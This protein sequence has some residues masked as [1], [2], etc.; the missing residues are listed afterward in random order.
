MP[1]HTHTHTYTTQI[2]AENANMHREIPKLQATLTSKM[3]R[4]GELEHLLR[5][6]KVAA[7]KEYMKLKAD[8]EQ[9]RESFME[10]LKETR[11]RGCELLGERDE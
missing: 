11:E 7:N 8:M 9:M 3:K 6:T 1:T 4:I 5:E 2:T 10:R